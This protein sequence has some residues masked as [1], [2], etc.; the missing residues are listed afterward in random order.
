MSHDIVGIVASGVSVVGGSDGVASS[1]DGIAG[2]SVIV[3][4]IDGRFQICKFVYTKCVRTK[5]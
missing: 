3:G 1:S 2:D 4:G 5:S